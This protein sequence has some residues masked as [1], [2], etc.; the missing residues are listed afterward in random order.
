MGTS[1]AVSVPPAIA[2]S[3]CPKAILL[4]ARIA[5]S[6][7]VPHA[8]WT[9]YA[10]VL[11]DNFELRVASRARLKSLAC[12]ITAPAATSPR[13]SPS[14]SKRLTSPLIEAVSISRLDACLYAVLLRT[15]G[16]LLPPKIA[17]LFVLSIIFPVITLKFKHHFYGYTLTLDK[18]NGHFIGNF[19]IYNGIWVNCIC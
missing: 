17:T 8:C 12:F 11:G 14:K 3:I 1:L 19:K 6:N 9:S 2:H 15:K 5:A 4:P 10:G 18:L 13:R 7:P 16:I